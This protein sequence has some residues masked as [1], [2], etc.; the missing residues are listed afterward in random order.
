M[1]ARTVRRLVRRLASTA[2]TDQAG[3]A[4]A[5]FDRLTA[6]YDR[7]PADVQDFRKQ[8]AFRSRNLGMKEL[9]LLVGK[10]AQTHLGALGR[11]ELQRFEQ[12]VLSLETPDLYQL[13]TSPRSDFDALELPG[14]HFLQAVR[15]FSERAD[16]NIPK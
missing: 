7:Q 16:W 2:Q 12:Q 6:A 11:E 15:S 1:I 14:S 3:P 9:D 13:L 4:Q 8:L 5:N 10:W